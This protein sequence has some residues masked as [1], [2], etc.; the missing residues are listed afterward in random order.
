MQ[1]EGITKIVFEFGY[2]WDVYVALWAYRRSLKLTGEEID[3]EKIGETSLCQ[4]F[5]RQTDL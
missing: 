2:V 1:R 5:P 3:G 4:F